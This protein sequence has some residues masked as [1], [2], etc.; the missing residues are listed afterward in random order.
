MIVLVHLLL[1]RNPLN[2]NVNVNGHA[3]LFIFPFVKW[4]EKK[5]NFSE[6]DFYNVCSVADPAGNIF[7]QLTS[8]YLGIETYCGPAYAVLVEMMSLER[9][10]AGLAGVAGLTC[11][12]CTL[13]NSSVLV[14]RLTQLD[15]FLLDSPVSLLCRLAGHA[16]QC[17][18]L[19]YNKRLLDRWEVR[20]PAGLQ[21]LQHRL[22]SLGLTA[23]HGLEPREPGEQMVERHRECLL[24]RHR[25]CT[26]LMQSGGGAGRECCDL[27]SRLRP[28]PPE[29]QERLRVVVVRR[30][31]PAESNTAQEQPLLLY[32]VPSGEEGVAEE[33]GNTLSIS[34]DE[35]EEKPRGGRTTRQRGRPA[36]LSHACPAPACPARFS[37]RVALARHKRTEHRPVWRCRQAGTTC[38][39]TFI[40]HQTRET[41]ARS[42]LGPF[43]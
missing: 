25:E 2:K 35:D 10:T 23:C 24:A 36:L 33:T 20:D 39:R 42:R 43:N 31:E 15:P 18:L 5:V 28:A 22:L 41:M 13:E 8:E 27:C 30:E 7:L 17:N 19:S 21:R 16:V 14:V 34:L 38:A 4:F 26:A 32:S 6:D 11:A 3:N 12:L 29:Q 9:V 40:R 37:S 1:L